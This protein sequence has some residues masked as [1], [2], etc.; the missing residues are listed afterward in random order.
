MI[1]KVP[2]CHECS[3]FVSAGTCSELRKKINKKIT[4]NLKFVKPVWNLIDHLNQVRIQC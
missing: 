1:Y 3:V 4:P 2:N